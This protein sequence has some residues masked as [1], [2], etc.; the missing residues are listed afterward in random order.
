MQLEEDKV[1]LAA[2]AALEAQEAEGRDEQM[3]GD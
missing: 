1:V 3:N 2:Q